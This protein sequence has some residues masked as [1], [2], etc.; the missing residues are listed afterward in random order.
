M[1]AA[2]CLTGVLVSG[3]SSAKNAPLD[4]DA[5]D[6]LRVLADAYNKATEKNNRPPKGPE[7]LKPFLPKD[8]SEEKVY[9]SARDGQPFVIIW[10]ADPRTGRDLKPLV[11]AYEKN[12]KGGARMV[13]TAMGVMSISNTDFPSASFPAGHKP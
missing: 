2:A 5:S 11:I 1:I 13:F 12:G 6:S 9:R 4:K 3:C 10:G 7:E 8:V